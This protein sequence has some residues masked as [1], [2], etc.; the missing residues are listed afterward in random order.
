MS[1]TVARATETAIAVTPGTIPAEAIHT[2][3]FINNVNDLFDSINGNLRY[4]FH[5]LCTLIL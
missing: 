1:A 4:K 3:T 5:R 2:A